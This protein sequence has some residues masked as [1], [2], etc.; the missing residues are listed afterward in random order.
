VDAVA[1]ANLERLLAQGQASPAELERLQQAY[2]TH[3]ADPVLLTALRGE[4]AGMDKNAYFSNMPIPGGPPPSVVNLP[5]PGWQD[6]NFATMLQFMNR[7]VEA[8]KLPPDEQCREFA[9][10]EKDIKVIAGSRW[11]R[12]MNLHAVL[13]LPAMEKVAVADSRRQ[14][15]QGCAILALAAER[16]RLQHGKWPEKI[17]DLKPLVKNIPIDPFATGPLKLKRTPDGLIIYSVGADE[18]DNG[19]NLDRTQPLKKGADLGFQ[20]WD[21]EK[22]RQPAKPPTQVEPMGAMP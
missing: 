11:R 7:G 17:E 2:E 12:L 9:E 6:N 18:Q 14:V 8:A 4:R 22:R 20:L 10:W 19:G 16:Y 13:M 5:V 1:A 15:G 21:V 3:L